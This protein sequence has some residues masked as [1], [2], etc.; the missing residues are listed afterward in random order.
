MNDFNVFNNVSI[1]RIVFLYRTPTGIYS[2]Q[3]IFGKI[4]KSIEFSNWETISRAKKF[5]AFQK[6]SVF[7]FWGRRQLSN[8][9]RKKNP[10]ARKSSKNSMT[11]K[12]LNLAT[13][14][15]LMG[16]HQLMNL[17]GY[18]FVQSLPYY[19]N[20]WHVFD[21][22]DH[23]CNIYAQFDCSEWCTIGITVQ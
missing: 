7:F 22:I 4:Q 21:F 23:S 18:V 15:N 13:V 19:F 9:D 20:L 8:P 6:K 10:F 3:L 17:K 14:N 5:P 1:N 16:L 11:L 2:I 12:Y